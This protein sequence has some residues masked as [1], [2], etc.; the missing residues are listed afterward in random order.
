MIADGSIPA[1]PAVSALQRSPS[2]HEGCSLPPCP[3]YSCES[4][5]Q[6]PPLELTLSLK[7]WEDRLFYINILGSICIKTEIDICQKYSQQ[8]SFFLINLLNPLTPYDKG[9]KVAKATIR[10]YS[11]SIYFGST[12]YH[13]LFCRVASFRN[14][15]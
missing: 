2:H 13:C 14:S 12:V 1:S 10:I 15:V 11:K 7:G 6:C 9:P 3:G 5:T 4:E 8:Y